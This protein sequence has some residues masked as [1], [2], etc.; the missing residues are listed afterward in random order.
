MKFY[1]QYD[2][3]RHKA[4]VVLDEDPNHIEIFYVDELICLVPTYS[5]LQ[6]ESPMFVMRG[7]CK[8]IHHGN[9]SITLT[10]R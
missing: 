1:F 8:I 5:V 7:K 6:K 10:D 2:K 3:D 9:N 4:K